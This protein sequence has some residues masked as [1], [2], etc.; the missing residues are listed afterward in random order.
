[1]LPS[2][3]ATTAGAGHCVEGLVYLLSARDE[4]RLDEYEGVAVGCYAKQ[5]LN[6]EVFTASIGLVG[7]LVGDLVP[8]LEGDDDD[9]FSSASNYYHLQQQPSARGE[10]AEALVY[11]SLLFQEEGRI[12]DEY[13][14]RMNAGIVDACKLGVSDS[15]VENCLRRYIPE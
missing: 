4:A 7:R 13:I 15:Y 10:M 6:V 2:T 9:T 8:L 1:M 5:F 12:R 11:V 3:T 14:A